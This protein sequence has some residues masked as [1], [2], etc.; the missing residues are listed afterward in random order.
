[1]SLAK[2]FKLGVLGA[3]VAL[4]LAGCGPDGGPEA[5]GGPLGMRRLTD[6]QYRQTIADIFGTDIKLAGR[7][8]PDQR[9]DGLV[10]LGAS[11]VTVSPTG[12]EQYDAIARNIAAQ[13]VDK[14]H[15][16]IL[17]GCQPADAAQPDAACAKQFLGRVG[18]LILRRPLADAK[19]QALVDIAAEETKKSGNFYSGIEFTLAG[20]L[21]SPNFL[22]RVEQ[23]VPAP[24]GGLQVDAYSKAA[25]LSYLMWNTAPDE[26]LLAAAASGALDSKEGLA[27]QVD[28]LA[29][30]PR[31]AT[32]VR[33]FFADMLAFEEFDR[34]DK[35]RAVYP[36]F[37][38]TVAEDAREQALRTIADHLI[39]RNG[40]YRDL[41]TTRKTFMTRALGTVYRVPVGAEKGWE[42]FE[43][44]ANDPRA[45]LL[46]QLSFT[47]LHAQ[48][49]RSSPTLRGKAVRELLLCQVVPD[50]PANVS[51]SLVE[52]TENPNLKTTRD[53]LT[54]HRNNETC[55][56]CHKVID[57]IGLALENFDGLGQYRD[58]EHGTA[59]DASGELNGT[60][61]KDPVGL[62]KVLR[63]D[64]GISS[65]LV[66][67]LYRYAVGRLPAANDQE[68]VEY[69]KERF[70][71][72]G[73]KVPALIKRIA[74]SD[75]FYAVKL[76]TDAQ[77]VKEAN[78]R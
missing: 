67:R 48:T 45:G 19:L 53:R 66:D 76:D 33:A 36:R 69:L 75:S 10:A 77:N 65:C 29:G 54:A 41:F 30:S 16:D 4:V 63:D 22:F 70:A 57:P 78:S 44:P 17:V 7:L 21:V 40:D 23:A 62:G 34:L 1:V 73:H 56:G 50:P 58:S 6:A 20:L 49:S 43:F 55:A 59:I 39:T 15:R 61:F 2:L 18:Q 71:S 42:A 13:V 47:A 31:L 5:S 35:N 24:N 38:R 72:D 8:Q 32:G 60:E 28:R 9:T 52:D 68:W 27:K 11:Q 51:F 25:R 74:L 3:G 64:P 37:S 12:I 26:E 14:D 46:T